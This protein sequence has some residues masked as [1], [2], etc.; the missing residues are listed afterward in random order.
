MANYYHYYYIFRGYTKQH[1]LSADILYIVKQ[2]R[3]RSGF[4]HAK[5]SEL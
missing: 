5:I 4:I 2:A 1:A 3:F